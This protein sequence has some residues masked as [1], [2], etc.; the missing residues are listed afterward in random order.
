LYPFPVDGSI[1]LIGFSG[2]KSGS[3]VTIDSVS[4]LSRLLSN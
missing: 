1:T 3:T 4:P 2:C